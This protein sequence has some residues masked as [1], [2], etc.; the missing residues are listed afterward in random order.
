MTDPGPLRPA[1]NSLQ[2]RDI[3]YSAHPY[4]NLKAH[5]QT[6]PLVITRGHGIHVYDDE[7]RAYIEGL[8]GLWCTALGFSEERLVDAAV[9]ADAQAALLSQLR[10]QGGAADASSWPR[11]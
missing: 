10:R 2:A 7:G 5:Q 3:A 8:A 9:R 4:T 11:S 1:P 6:G